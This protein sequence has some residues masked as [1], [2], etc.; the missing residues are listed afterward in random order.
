ML[1]S[2]LIEHARGFLD[3]PGA[4]RWPRLVA[5]LTRQAIETQLEHL[6]MAVAPGM[7]DSSTRAQLIALCEYVPRNLAGEVAWAWDRLSEVCHHH[8]YELAPT[9]AELRD[10][11]D[12]ADRFTTEV[13]EHATR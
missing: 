2:E 11:L 6:W 5:I 4:L 7:Q 9:E 1:P 3:A 8:V 10:W 13:R 12:R